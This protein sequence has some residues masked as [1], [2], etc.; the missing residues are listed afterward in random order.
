MK[1]QICTDKAPQP[2]G[3]YSQGLR[4][5]NRIYVA[6]QGPINPQTGRV[7]ATDIAGQTHQVLKNIQTILQEAGASLKDV[8]KATVHLSDL[9]YFDEFNKVYMQYFEQPYP[10]RTTVGSQLNGILVEIDV[11]AEI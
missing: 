2:A 3:P 7:E 11:I 4:V 10:V 8:V 6:G 1:E 5:G 9:K